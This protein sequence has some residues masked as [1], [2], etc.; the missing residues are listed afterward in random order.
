MP[1]SEASHPN[2]FVA[3]HTQ[4]ISKVPS[5]VGAPEFK[6]Q[7]G[8]NVTVMGILKAAVVSPACTLSNPP[9][10]ILGKSIYYVVVNGRNYRL[11]FLNSSVRP[12]QVIGYYLGITGLYVTPS[13]FNP[14]QWT[15][16]IY[17]YGDIYVQVYFFVY[18]HPQ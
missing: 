16:P 7:S 13:S 17:F 9:C 8:V 11:I 15:P 1:Y 4:T 3:E 6:T 14:T 2:S 10:S 18:P 5:E 12:D